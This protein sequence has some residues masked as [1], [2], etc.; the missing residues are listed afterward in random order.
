[1]LSDQMLTSRLF[2]AANGTNGTNG[3]K[4]SDA[5]VKDTFTVAFESNSV[6]RRDLSRLHPELFAKLG[7][8]QSPEILWIGCADSRCPETT[9]LGKHPP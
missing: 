1:M 2:Q 5:P 7:K 8:G 4:A 6:W 3:T 9:I